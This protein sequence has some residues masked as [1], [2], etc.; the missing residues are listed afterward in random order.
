MSLELLRGEE[1]SMRKGK[2]E[3]H[4]ESVRER[5]GWRSFKRVAIEKKTV[6]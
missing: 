6:L 4:I 5:E 1:T 3:C 2:R